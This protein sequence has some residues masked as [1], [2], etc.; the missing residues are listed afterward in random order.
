M[1]MSRS[2]SIAL[3]VS[4]AVVGACAAA[5][6]PPAASPAAMTEDEKTLYALGLMLGRRLPQGLF[7]QGAAFLGS[8]LLLTLMVPSSN[9]RA[10]LLL[11]TALAAAQ[12]QRFKERG[13]ESAFLGLAAFFGAVPLLYI[14]L[15][16]SSSNFLGL[17]LMPEHTRARFDLGWATDDL[18]TRRHQ[19]TSVHRLGQR[20]SWN[21]ETRN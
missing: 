19:G 20:D 21:S 11:P 18:N 5:Q 17:G 4:L 14:F 6:A 15:N 16:G 10:R 13:P 9:A 12:S 7:A 3:A 2:A 8:G 1:K